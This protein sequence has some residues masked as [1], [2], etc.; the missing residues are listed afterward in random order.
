M[1]TEAQIEASRLNGAKSKGPVTEEGRSRSSQNASRHGMAG[2]KLMAIEGESQQEWQE[3]VEEHVREFQPESK[4]EWQLVVEIAAA[5]WRLRRSK[6]VET[7]MIDLEIARQ[8]SGLSETCETVDEP[9]RHASAM[10]SLAGN[11]NL[12]DRYET[13]AARAYERA[14]RNFDSLRA[15]RRKVFLPNEPK[16]LL[17]PDIEISGRT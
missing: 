5:T 15:R 6:F 2:H 17:V 14:V 3:N 4:L 7:A 13:R 10:L 1:R 8:R 16:Q 9:L 11:I 12:L